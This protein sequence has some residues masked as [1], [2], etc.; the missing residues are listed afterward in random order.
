MAFGRKIGLG[1]GGV[2]FAFA[3]LLLLGIS[4]SFI[5]NGFSFEDFDE[6]PEPKI[7]K[8]F[9][10]SSELMALEKSLNQS[11]KKEYREGEYMCGHFSYDLINLLNENDI[12]ARMMIGQKHETGDVHAW[13]SIDID[14]QTGKIESQKIDDTYKLIDVCDITSENEKMNCLAGN[15]IDQNY[16]KTQLADNSKSNASVE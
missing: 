7:Q 4:F 11:S 5:Q 16:Y 3:I 14:P 8:T 9:L 2:R 13:I 12:K 15:K 10:Q 6:R 1:G